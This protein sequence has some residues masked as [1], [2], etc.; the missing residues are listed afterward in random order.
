M[1]SESSA[2]AVAADAETTQVNIE[3]VADN[4]ASP[5]ALSALLVAVVGT[6]GLALLP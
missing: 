5:A 2:A 6:V 1:D 3:A 4:G